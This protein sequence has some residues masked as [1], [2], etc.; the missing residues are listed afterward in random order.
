MRNLLENARFKRAA[1]FFSHSF[2]LLVAT[3]ALAIGLSA[4]FAEEIRVEQA[5]MARLAALAEQEREIVCL[6]NI[7]H[8]E[9]RGEIVGVRELI[10]KT[11][12]A[13]A[14]DPASKSAKTICGLAKTPGLFSQFKDAHGT[15]FENPLWHSIY[16]HMSDVYYGPRTL[17]NGWGCVRGF[18]V[19]DD[20]LEKLGPKAIAQLGFTVKATGLKYFAAHRVPVDTRGRVTFYA[21]RG[22]CKHPAPTSV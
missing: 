3:L 5:R 21:P 22:G 4:I 10:A 1:S 6:A 9:A 12:L 2:S 17:P 15:K 7:V 8:H 11:V 19:S 20:E 13:I 14:A 16:G 18:R